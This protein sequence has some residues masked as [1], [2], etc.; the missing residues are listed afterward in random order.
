MSASSRA[1]EWR[2]KNPEKYSAFVERQRLRR[3][4]ARVENPSLATSKNVADL[5]RKRYGLTEKMFSDLLTSQNGRCAICF[6]GIVEPRSAHV[7]HDHETGK[8]RGLLCMSCN[9]G[10]GLLRDSPDVLL[11]AL[12]YL[13]K[14]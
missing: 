12:E 14:E 11:S 1:K 5:R 2:E 3:Q 8:V 9:R 10:L 13:V 6:A 7:D 4:Q